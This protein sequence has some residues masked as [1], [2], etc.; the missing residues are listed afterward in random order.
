[1]HLSARNFTGWGSEVVKKTK[2]LMELVDQ[3]EDS[4]CWDLPYVSSRVVVSNQ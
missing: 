4:G 2:L 1:M 3:D